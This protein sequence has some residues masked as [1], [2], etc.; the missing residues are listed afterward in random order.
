MFK[1]CFI[2]VPSP[3]EG[4]RLARLL[5]EEKAAACVNLVPQITSMYWWEG[6]I[7]E[8]SEVLLMVKTHQD[9]LSRLIELIQQHHPYKVAEV[10]SLPIETG[11][12]PYLAWMSECLQADVRQGNSPA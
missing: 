10:I 7:Q 8:D 11:N 3:E 4:K 5:L 9:R 1:V 12:P 2:T 6:S